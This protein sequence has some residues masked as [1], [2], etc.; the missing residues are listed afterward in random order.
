MATFHFVVESQ[1]PAAQIAAGLDIA[2]SAGTL[3]AVSG[4]HE[5]LLGDDLTHTAPQNNTNGVASWEFTWQAPAQPGNATLFGAGNS[6]NLDFTS[7][8][9][10]AATTT[11]QIVVSD[12]SPPT[13][14]ET[15]TDIPTETPTATGRSQ[16]TRSWSASPSRS[17]RPTEVCAR[18]WTSTR[19]AR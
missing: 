10:A 2:T 15:P 16:S 9:D 6:V 14:T 8:G 11:F 3:G 4:Q 18:L 13:P 1:A 5:Q 7:F 17:V 19:T 12:A